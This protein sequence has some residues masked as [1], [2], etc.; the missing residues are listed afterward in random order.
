MAEQLIPRGERRV[1]KLS[2]KQVQEL[3][4]KFEEL[5]RR[6]ELWEYIWQEV[7]DFVLPRLHRWGED[8]VPAKYGMK[9]YDGTAKGALRL[10][11]DGLQGY[12]TPRTASWFRL[13]LR[14][15]DLMDLPGVRQWVE[16]AEEQVYAALNRSNFYD[17][18]GEIFDV[19]LSVGTASLWIEEDI[20]NDRLHFSARPP[21]EVYIAENRYGAVDTWMRIYK[22]S[23]K[24][25]LEEFGESPLEQSGHTNLL[26]QMKREPFKRWDVQHM[27]FPREDRIWGKIDNQ[28]KPIASVYMLKGT[29][30]IL[31]ESG[32]DRMPTITWRYRVQP[33]EEYGT[34][35]AIDALVDTIRSNEVSR[36][37]ML[38]RQLAVEPPMV[39]P[40]SMATSLN[41]KPRGMNPMVNPAFMPQTMD[42]LGRFPQW[43]AEQEMKLQQMIR[44]HFNADFF[45]LLS[46]QQAQGRTA[47]EVMEMAGERAAVMGATVGRV[48][49][50][51]LDPLL[52]AV[53]EMEYEA[54]R[55]PPAPEQL[56][57]ASPDIAFDYIGP[58][59]QIQ[60]K[61]YGQ[62][63]IIQTLMQAGPIIELFPEVR[64]N[65]DADVL[66][67]RVVT[68]GGWA[69]DAIRD[70]DTV[71]QI[72]QSRAEQEAAMIAAQQ[73]QVAAQQYRD[74][75][76]APQPGS[77]AEAL[78]Q[79]MAR[80]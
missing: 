32:F 23:A 66:F 9:A 13:Q 51:Y 30:T 61:H 71:A 26:Q 34:S 4:G 49:S 17:Q 2:K 50:E 44:Q 70:D 22:V 53:F 59:A 10:A 21:R 20:R 12:L 33:G 37:D 18:N 11:S 29:N 74:T 68:S 55:I 35:P 28:N 65:I 5:K 63:S 77:P 1:T 67:K 45:L 78:A 69:A 79:R 72:R 60:R 58:L 54:G 15:D 41:I 75:N 43:G 46:Q 14:P 16:T 42:V 48:E 80:G 39:V 40:Q 47:T 56:L 8:D 27:I 73:E 52:S 7:T 24:R 6:R 76:E 64:D 25:I 57:D 62:Q 19:G 31:R 36:T 3:S 38:A